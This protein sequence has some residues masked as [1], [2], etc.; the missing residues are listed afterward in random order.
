MTPTFMGSEPRTVE[1]GPLA[2]TE[3]FTLEESAGLTMIRSLDEA[4]AAKAILRPSILPDDLPP[5]LKHPFDGRMQAGAFNDNATLGYEGISADDLS[6]RQRNLLLSLIASYVGWS[7]EGHA[8]LRMN[9]VE[10]FL[11]ETWFS[12]SGGTSDTATFYY[13]VH[14]P[15]VLIEFDHHPGVVFDNKA[16]SR[17]HVHSLIRTP[18]GGDYGVDLLRQHHERF[19]HSHGRHDPRPD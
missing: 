6:D 10:R 3:L 13:R 4:Q 16:P 18:N 7:N 8:A 9:D 1:E 12:W 5:A 2:G 17:H 19:D 15:V 14:S 11:D